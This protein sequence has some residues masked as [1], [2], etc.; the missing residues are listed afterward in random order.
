MDPKNELLKKHFL[1][2]RDIVTLEKA[3]PND[4]DYGREIRKIIKEYNKCIIPDDNS[5]NKR[6]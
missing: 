5:S 4:A 1:T 6:V 3:L 2:M